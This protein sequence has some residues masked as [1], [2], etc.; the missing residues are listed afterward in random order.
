MGVEHCRYLLRPEAAGF[1]LLS[2]DQDQGCGEAEPGISP[3]HWSAI[4]IHGKG[5]PKVFK[6]PHLKTQGTWI[7]DELKAASLSQGWLPP[8]PTTLRDME[9]GSRTWASSSPT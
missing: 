3:D 8:L 1:S 4:V 7:E 5:C 6:P 2:M 9:G